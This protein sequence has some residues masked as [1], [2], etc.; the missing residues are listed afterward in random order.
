MEQRIPEHERRRESNVLCRLKSFS[1]YQLSELPTSNGVTEG[2]QCWYRAA[3]MA[4]QWSRLGSASE[5]LELELSTLTWGNTGLKDQG[6]RQGSNLQEQRN[7]RPEAAMEQGDPR[8][9]RE[10]ETSEK[11]RTGRGGWEDGKEGEYDHK[12]PWIFMLDVHEPMGSWVGQ[13]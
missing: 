11:V 5:R 7:Q 10:M 1:G 6:A 2:I 3:R 8:T 13:E 12:P 4:A 9:Q